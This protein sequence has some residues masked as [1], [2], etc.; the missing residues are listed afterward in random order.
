MED[1]RYENTRLVLSICSLCFSC[2]TIG[3]LIGMC[4]LLN[5]YTTSSYT[6]TSHST[7]YGLDWFGITKETIEEKKV[8]CTKKHL[9]TIDMSDYY[10]ALEDA[11]KDRLS[12]ANP[13][14]YGPSGKELYAIWDVEPAIEYMRMLGYDEETYPYWVSDD[15][16]KMF[17]DYIICAASFDE[18]GE[19]GTIVDTSLGKAMICD[20]GGSFEK[21]S[22]IDIATTWEY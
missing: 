11:P 13:I 16:V 1:E 20:T 10:Q 6:E 5:S 21:D 15:G 14:W 22:Y 8:E 12:I 19:R 4:I 2:V 18:F 17:G 7:H 9:S 3:L